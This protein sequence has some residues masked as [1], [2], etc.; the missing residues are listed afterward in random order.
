MDEIKKYT[1]LIHPYRDGKSSMRVLDAAETFIREYRGK[2]KRK[3][4]NLFRRIKM[5]WKH[6]VLF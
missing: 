3:P 5:R 1:D 2:I 4:L 6:K